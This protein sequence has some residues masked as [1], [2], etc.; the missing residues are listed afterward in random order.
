MTQELTASYRAAEEVARTRARNFYYSFVVLP[1]EKRRAL[2]AV[3]A[4]MRFCDD[5]SDGSA[6]IPE[7][8]ALLEKWRTRLE[9]A[10]AGDFEGNPILRSF[11]DAVHKFHIPIEYFHWAIDGA[12]MDLTTDR[13]QTFDDLYRYCFN[14]ASTVG[15]ICIQIFGFTDECAKKHAE[16]CGIAFQLTN[17]LRDVKEDADMGRIYLPC[18]DLTR[19]RYSPEDLGERILDERFQRLMAYQTERARKYY[20]Q[21]RNLFPLIDQA[22]RPA[23]WAMMEIYDR[24]L[25]KIVRQRYDVFQKSIRLSN[26]EKASIAL[27]ALAM[28]FMPGKIWMSP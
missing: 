14:V 25:R 2:C 10:F 7:K 5:I 15:L 21:G 24:L 3:Y 4:F 1:P 17:I 9:G 6:S 26:P 8:R 12:E 28:R 18:E 23:L 13:Y 27:R 22:C 11:S 16:H 20:T 19:F